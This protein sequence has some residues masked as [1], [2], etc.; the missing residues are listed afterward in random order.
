M[1]PESTAARTTG[2][3]PID[4]VDARLKLILA[5]CYVVAVV[6]VPPGR[7]KV[8]AVLALVLAFVIG[9]SGAS[10]QVLLRRWAG[11]LLLSG[12]LAVTI[13][14][15]IAARRGETVGEVVLSIV[16]RNGLAL[17]MMLTLAEVTPFPVLLRALGRLGV[18]RVLIE[19]LE[20]ME[21]YIHVLLEELE[22][23]AT[24]RRARSFRNRRWLPWTTL[25]GLIGVLLIR[26]LD[27]AERVHSAMLARGWDG[28]LR[29]LDDPRADVAGRRR[30]V[31]SPSDPEAA[32]LP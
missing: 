17:L 9:V 23:M 6:A 12:F 13:A 15:G 28:N 4:R 26:S 3:G 19:T 11:L 2:R 18:P 29:R 21:R 10:L 31:H 20:F 14:P 24:A 32:G 5:V 1:W 30:G 22:R 25:S 27:R 16:A 7:W 8:L